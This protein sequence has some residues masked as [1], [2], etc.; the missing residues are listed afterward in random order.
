MSNT[1]ISLNPKC[2]I[3]VFN[4]LRPELEGEEATSTV[5]ESE[6]ID[7]SSYL[8]EVTFNKTLRSPS[9]TFSF[10]LA[11]DRDWKQFI[12]PGA[13]CLIY[14]CNDGAIDIPSIKHSDSQEKNFLS[15]QQ[16]DLRDL[17]DIRPYLRCIGYIETVRA[18]GSVGEEKGEFDVDYVVSGRDFGSIYETTEIY[19]NRVQFDQT[20]LLSAGAFIKNPPEGK[21]V[22]G[23]LKLLH[24]LIFAPSKIVKKDDLKS[25]N[26][27]ATQWL[28]PS[29]MLKALEINI[30]DEPYYG[31][32]P[33]LFKFTPSKCSFPVENPLALLNGIAWERLKAHSIEPFHELFPELDKTGYPKLHF[34]PIPWR[35]TDGAAYPNISQSIPK[36]ADYNFFNIIEL[37]AEDIIGF[38]L[39]EDDHARYNLFWAIIK[40]YQITVENSQAPTLNQSSIKRHGLRSM[41]TEINALITLGSEK[42]DPQLIVDY[43]NLLQE[44]Y[45]YN[46]LFESGSI[47]IIGN[48]SIRV[49]EII[50]FDSST[51]YNEDKYF[52]IEG[53][54]DTFTLDDKGASSWVQSLTVTRGVSGDYL[55]QNKFDSFERTTDY[56]FNGDI[57]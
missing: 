37:S 54:Q 27:V 10:S 57:T 42:A 28:L 16:S 52:Y 25:L 43:N 17:A 32:I 9:G 35:I 2:R 48:N 4:W 46:H 55:T 38:D 41:I 22:D 56:K 31:N 24:D 21:T 44:Y 13:W 12:R 18:K 40:S 7:V 20:L 47:D 49:G 51:A 19:H 53:Y 11:N 6:G 36:F 45:K 1:T 30:T 5:A 15:M 3:V 34:R 23:L 26:S 33:D 14:M 29:P 39:G 50:H 8:K